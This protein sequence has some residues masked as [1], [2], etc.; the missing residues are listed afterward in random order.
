[1]PDIP[2]N[3]IQICWSR[4]RYR[5]HMKVGIPSTANRDTERY[6]IVNALQ[7][8]RLQIYLFKHTH[9]H[10]RSHTRHVCESISYLSRENILLQYFFFTLNLWVYM[11]V[12][13][14]ECIF[15]IDTSPCRPFSRCVTQYCL[16]STQNVAIHWGVCACRLYI[17]LS[18]FLSIYSIGN[19]D[20]TAPNK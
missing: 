3:Q 17:F 18:V 5:H 2:P 1:M 20:V 10:T 12:C 7:T 15:I 13:H 4:G 19:T 9:T 14:I 8:H 6:S 11:Y 16:F